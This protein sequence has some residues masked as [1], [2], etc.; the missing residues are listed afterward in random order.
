MKRS[1]RFLLFFLSVVLLGSYLLCAVGAQGM[2]K[3]EAVDALHELVN[4]H[5]AEKTG[6]SAQTISEVQSVVLGY[7]GRASLVGCTDTEAVL[8]YRKGQAAGVLSWIYYTHPEV[9]PAEGE[10]AEENAI[11]SVYVTQRGIVDGKEESELGFFVSD[12]EGEPAVYACYT[13]LLDAIYA[14]RIR[15]LR[16]GAGESEAALAMLDNA[17]ACLLGG[18]GAVEDTEN[19]TPSY[20]DEDAE[21]YRVYFEKVRQAVVRQRER[22]AAAE[23]LLA[24]YNALFAPD[25]PYVSL[26]EIDNGAVADFCEGLRSAETVAQMN[27]LLLRALN[28]ESADTEAGSGERAGLLA[29]AAD[30]CSAYTKQ[31]LGGTLSVRVSSVVASA[32]SA[33]RIAE[34]AE[35]CFGGAYRLGLAKAQAKDTLAERADAMS[36][37]PQAQRDTLAELLS[38][39]NA[40]SGCFDRCETVEAVTAQ[41]ERAACRLA[42]LAEYLA[43]LADMETVIADFPS[44]GLSEVRTAYARRLRL[45]YDEVAHAIGEGEERDLSE[46]R[47]AL[48]VLITEA[49]AQAYRQRHAVFGEDGYVAD[50]IAEA[51]LAAALGDADKLSAEAQALLSDSL[52][53]AL[54]AYKACLAKTVAQMIPSDA[55]YAE[56]QKLATGVRH[57]LCERLSALLPNGDADTPYAEWLASADSILGKAE[58]AGRVLAVYREKLGGGFDLRR[59]DM[60]EVAVEATNG[61]LQTVDGDEEEIAEEAVSRLEQLADLALSERAAQAQAAIGAQAERLAQT[62]G[63][64]RYLSRADREAF[65]TELAELRRE[66]EERIAAAEAVGAVV[67]A[68]REGT[69]ALA[70][71]AERVGEKEMAACVSFVKQALRDS[72]TE[73]DYSAE[74]LLAIRDVTDACKEALA[75]AKDVAECEALLADALAAIEAIPNLLEDA[76]S[77]GEA[78]LKEVYERLLLRQALYSEEKLA[79]LHGLYTDTLAKIRSMSEVADALALTEAVEAAVSAMAAL[80]ISRVVTDDGIFTDTDKPALPDGYDPGVS[81]YFGEI[82]CENGLPSDVSLTVTCTT[83][84]DIAETLKAA[85]K[86]RKIYL[87]DGSAVSAEVWKLLKNCY[88][89]AAMSIRPSRELTTSG[90]LYRVSL[91][92]PERVMASA[93]IGVVFVREDGSAEFFPIT[94]ED[95]VLR[96]DT[97]HFSNFYLVSESSVNLVPWIVLLCVIIFCEALALLLLWVRKARRERQSAVSVCAVLPMGVLTVYR[98]AGGVA[99]LWWLGALAVL[100]GGCLAWVIARDVRTRRV[101]DGE[102]EADCEPI[103]EEPDEMKEKTEPVSVP[104]CEPLGEVTAQEADCLM[105]D[106]EAKEELSERTEGFFGDE[107]YRGCKKAEVNIDTISQT[108]PAGAVVTLNSLKEKKLVPPSTGFVKI[109][110]RGTLD[111]PLTVVAQDFSTAALKMILLTGGRAVVAEPSPERRRRVPEGK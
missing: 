108:F 38:E 28:G 19:P 27:G 90:G 94:S 63:G 106:R 29:Q 91:L 45:L 65:L 26:G 99:V 109:L 14:Q 48:M 74:R 53:D 20:A 79:E 60:N 46:S 50:G 34:L 83:D 21:N 49:E 23:Q 25:A 47:R 73:S 44:A 17:V 59:T 77:A 70:R 95:G 87:A 75:G 107:E 97:S 84:T 8:L 68:E 30:G 39:Y 101:A 105:S 80:P 96:F 40:A 88:V 33:G 54:G 3:R 16:Q 2:T 18:E 24:A 64:Y 10:D 92:L 9:H 56:W 86:A 67:L 103:G 100:L 4:K 35:S 81:G 69:E 22:D 6:V 89:S 61:I 52:T 93:V 104:V 110:A 1:V 37:L 32:T 13:R 58:A 15:G 36:E 12:G 98:P 82:A 85:A 11:Y 102:S 31:Y 66:S 51:A 57:T 62:I 7:Y 71:L 72:Y 78:R 76:L 55:V 41:S 43:A 5:Y 42:W 111:K